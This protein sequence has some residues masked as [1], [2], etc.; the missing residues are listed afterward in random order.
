MSFNEQ[1]F[2]SV[3][4]FSRETEPVGDISIC[5]WKEIYYKELAH[6]IMEAD[7]S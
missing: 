3:L 1:K 4:G 6:G 7:K 5:L 2:L